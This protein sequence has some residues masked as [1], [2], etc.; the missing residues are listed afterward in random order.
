MKYKLVATSVEKQY[1]GSSRITNRTITQSINYTFDIQLKKRNTLIWKDIC[2]LMFVAALFTVANIWIQ[3]KCP[4]MNKWIKKWDGDGERKD[5][6]TGQRMSLLT[7]LMEYLLILSIWV[8]FLCSPDAHK[9]NG[10]AA[11]PLWTEE[12]QNVINLSPG[13]PVYRQWYKQ[14]AVSVI[15]ENRIGWENR[16]NIFSPRYRGHF[17]RCKDRNLSGRHSA[18]SQRAFIDLL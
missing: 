7:L 15:W 17:M 4:W 16:E 11:R 5:E 3:Y 1:G 8:H 10:T 18:H 9:W 12:Y 14:C 2:S 13:C 6:K